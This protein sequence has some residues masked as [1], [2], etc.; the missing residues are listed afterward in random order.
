MDA[1]GRLSFLEKHASDK[2]VASALLT[3][4]GFLS[5]LSEAEIGMVRSKVEKD[6]LSPEIVKARTEVENALR[7]AKVGWGRAATMIAQRG[8]LKVQAVK[9]EEAA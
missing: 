2:M 1:S 6:A 5:G 8:G 9:V 7:E 4:P 3:A